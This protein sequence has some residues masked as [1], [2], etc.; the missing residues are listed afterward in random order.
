MK[1][2]KMKHRILIVDDDELNSTAFAKRLERKGFSTKVLT[3]A[4]QAMDILN[5]ECFDLVLLDIVMPE[6]DGL[7]LLKKIR[8]RYPQEELPV[9]MVTMIDDSTDVLDAFE[10]GANDYITKPISIDAAAAR[11]QGQLN[12]TEVHRARV[13][14]K[15]VEAITAMVITCHHE[16][17]NPLAIIHGQLQAMEKDKQILDPNRLKKIY[18]AIDRITATLQKIKEVSEQT[19]ISYQVYTEASNTIK[20][21]RQ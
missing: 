15:E 20:L 18:S 3:S 14:L 6:M 17:N 2:E 4:N 10:L 21:Q 1:N 16:I 7:T 8:E 5:M 19:E 11:I 12:S 9:V 13:K